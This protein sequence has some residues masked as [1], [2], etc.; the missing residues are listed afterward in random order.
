MHLF[1]TLL[2]GHLIADFP[3]QTNWVFALKL[4]NSWGIAL[5]VAI[6]IVITA[7]L[8]GGSI[9]A[10]PLL[11]I[12]ALLHFACDWSKLN[13]PCKSQICSFLLDQ[14]AHV[15]TLLLLTILYPTI[16]PILSM[17]I[18]LPALLYAILP[19]LMVS[20]AILGIEMSTN[21]SNLPAWIEWARNKGISASQTM[22]NALVASLLVS[23]LISALI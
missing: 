21:G 4:K 14:A 15:A 22:G 3:L 12:L 20:A 17:W 5:H 23:L 19:A 8:L 7:I 13:I 9:S 16:E 10:W 2:L 11:S 1:A 18:V 6:H